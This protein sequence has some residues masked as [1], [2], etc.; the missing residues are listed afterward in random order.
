VR[1]ILRDSFARQARPDGKVE[2]VFNRVYLI[3]HAPAC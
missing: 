3:A 2:L 1:T